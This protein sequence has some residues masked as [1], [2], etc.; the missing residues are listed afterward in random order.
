MEI[1]IQEIK[2]EIVLPKHSFRI[3]F[4]GEFLACQFSASNVRPNA[5]MQLHDTL[6]EKF[7]REKRE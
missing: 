5:T 7:P 3:N 6:R 2:L 1:I 4:R